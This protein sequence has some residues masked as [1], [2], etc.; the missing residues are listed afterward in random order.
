MKD[1]KQIFK[2]HGE[3]ISLS[4]TDS[5]WVSKIEFPFEVFTA[6]G[7][8]YEDFK[9]KGKIQPGTDIVIEIYEKES[10]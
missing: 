5:G 6:G 1:R 7:G 8:M 4:T 10:Q 9:I 2:T 3:C